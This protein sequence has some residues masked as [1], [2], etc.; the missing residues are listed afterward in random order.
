MIVGE[1]IIPLVMAAIGFAVKRY[2]ECYSKISED[3]KSKLSEN[4]NIST[5]SLEKY[6]EAIVKPNGEVVFKN[7]EVSRPSSVSSETANL[8]NTEK[9]YTTDK[10]WWEAFKYAFVSPI[11]NW[12]GGSS[13]GKDQEDSNGSIFDKY[14]ED[15]NDDVFEAEVIGDTGSGGDAAP[16]A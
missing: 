4:A 3:M 14:A 9:E 6:E 11:A 15:A 16:A 10:V 2:C 8:I 5:S 12:F 1:I 13:K 7:V